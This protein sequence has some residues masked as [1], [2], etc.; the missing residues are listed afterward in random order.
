MLNSSSMGGADGGKLT[1]ASSGACVCE[2]TLWVRFIDSG[3]ADGDGPTRVSSGGGIILTGTAWVSFVDSPPHPIMSFLLSITEIPSA[4]ADSIE[5]L[6]AITNSWSSETC[7]EVEVGFT[8][9]ET[10]DMGEFDVTAPSGSGTGTF[11]K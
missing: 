10:K 9:V 6:M 4:L 3:G 11:C 1:W 7:A 2:I 5:A 8:E